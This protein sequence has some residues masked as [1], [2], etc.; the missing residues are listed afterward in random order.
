M[1][2]KRNKVLFLDDD[3]SFLDV[4]KSLMA[5][6]ARDA[7]ARIERSKL[8]ALDSLRRALEQAL[9]LKFQGG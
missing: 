2:Q 4:L 7:K 1:P 6:Y 5:S 3:K 9:G 8:P